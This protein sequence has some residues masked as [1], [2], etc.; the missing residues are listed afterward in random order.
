LI[1]TGGLGP[2]FDDKTLAG[3]SKAVGSKLNVDPRA[4]KMIKDKYSYYAEKMGR[5]KIELTPARIKMATIPE[6]AELMPNPVGTAPA[7][8]I[9]KNNVTIFSLPGVPLEMKAIFE[10]TIFSLLKSATPDLTFFAT[11]LLLSGIME[12]E[13]APIID[14][15]MKDNP[16]IYI[17]SHPMGAEQTPNIEL[18]ISTTT[19]RSETAKKRISKVMVQL[20]EAARSK[21]GTA[22]AQPRRTTEAA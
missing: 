6:G 1:I 12:S 13:M 10:N 5:S 17:K 22:R 18:H 19:N 15:V 7:V 8:L 11:S 9:K 4:L 3:L 16:Y 20:S 14:Q 21:G 2:T